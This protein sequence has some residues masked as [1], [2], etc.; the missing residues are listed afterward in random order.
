[1]DLCVDPKPLEPESGRP[2]VHNR[3]RMGIFPREVDACQNAVSECPR[4]AEENRYQNKVNRGN[5][6]RAPSVVSRKN[7]THPSSPPVLTVE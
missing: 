5:N 2:E 3:R 7:E 4:R 1:M 6:F